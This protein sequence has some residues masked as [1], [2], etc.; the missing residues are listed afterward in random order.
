[1][2]QT[3]ET[4]KY[5]VIGSSGVGKT[6]ILT[7][8]DCNIFRQDVQPTI[9]VDFFVATVN[10]GDVSFKLHLWDTAGQERFHSIAKSYFRSAMGVFLVFDLTD[11]KSFDDMTQWLNDVHNLCDPN[12][13]VTLFGNKCDLDDSRVVLRSEAASFAFMH[14]LK[15]FETSAL[16][17]ENISEAIHES[18]TSLLERRQRNAGHQPPLDLHSDKQS[19]FTCPC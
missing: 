10:I 13:T 2:P 6:S 18:V 11:R 15:Y 16:L 4:F 3:L 9:G 7:R 5:I 19:L 1:M 14:Q 8:F 12:V 17:G